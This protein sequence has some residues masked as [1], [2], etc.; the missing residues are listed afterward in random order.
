MSI[1]LLINGKKV[2]VDAI[3]R[4]KGM[5]EFTLNGKHYSFHGHRNV[6]GT[7]TLEEGEHR[8]R[9]TIWPVGKGGFKLQLD[10]MEV[11]LSPVMAATSGAS[12]GETPLSP[13]A[14]MPGLVRQVLV[15]KGD[16]V[17]KGQALAVM[18]A[19]KLQTTLSAGGDAVVVEV[20]VKVG[21]LVSE[22]AEL[23]KLSAKA[24]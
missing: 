20:L 2:A 7:F 6:D 12:V 11:K 18:E 9:G 17:T 14:P 21:E 4:K 15:Q 16:K 22:G 1:E 23:V 8:H 13:T 3:E 24:A 19:M 5:V 10:A